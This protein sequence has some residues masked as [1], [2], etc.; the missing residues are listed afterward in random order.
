MNSKSSLCALTVAFLL[1][2]PGLRA[3]DVIDR[4]VA[5]VNGHIILQSDWDDAVRYEAF[6]NHRPLDGISVEERKAA[7]DHL[8]DQELLGEQVRASDTTAAD[9]QDV[10][11]RVAQV[12]KQY[13]D[14]GQDWSEALFRY[15]LTEDEVKKRTT[16]EI[17]LMRL[18]NLRLR[19]NV[20]VDSNSIESYY[21]Q[22]L[23][24]ELRKSGAK[25]VALSDVTPKIKEL[26]TQQK[27]N[28]L[29]TA[30]LQNLRAGSEIRTDAF[31]PGPGDA[32][33]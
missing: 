6:S 2:V 8:I 29:L 22:E 5:K 23:L 4:I 31:P 17:E 14:V 3:G 13:S 26:L 30:W 16:L 12:R 28:E 11:K 19:P 24:P 9:S 27:V 33:Q 10:E 15:G 7:L 1:L 20:E 21:N 18:V 32:A 25:E